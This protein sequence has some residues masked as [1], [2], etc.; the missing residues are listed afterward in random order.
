MT[1]FVGRQLHQFVDQVGQLARFLA[2]VV[3]EVGLGLRREFAEAPQDRDVGV[4][5]RQ[6]GAQLA[7]ALMNRPALLL[8]DEPTGALDSRS[9]RQVMDL[10][11]ELNRLGHTLLIVTHDAQLADRCATRLVEFSDGRIVRERTPERAS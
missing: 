6:R 10:L 5:A 3:Q 8:A 1:A 2:Q 4:Q 7:R 9:G 11:T